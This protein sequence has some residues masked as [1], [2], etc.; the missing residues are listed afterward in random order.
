MTIDPNTVPSGLHPLVY[1]V[2]TELIRG[3]AVK[4]GTTTDLKQ[5]FRSLRLASPVPL[6]VHAVALG[7]RHREV[8]FH[9]EFR[10]HRLHGE[11]FKI[12]PS[13]LERIE[14]F[15]MIFD[16]NVATLVERSARLNTEAVA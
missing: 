15:R 10:K 9:R 8:E 13:L 14:A 1:F 4:I 11:W 3:A 2:G 5:R 6:V 7:D 12:T 16:M